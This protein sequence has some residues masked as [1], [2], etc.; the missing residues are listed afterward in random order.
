MARVHSNDVV[1]KLAGIFLCHYCHP[2]PEEFSGCQDV[3]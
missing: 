2:F 3:N 1:A